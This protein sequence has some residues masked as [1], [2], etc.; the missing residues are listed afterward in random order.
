MDATPAQN[1]ADE[2][3]QIYDLWR[4]TGEMPTAVDAYPNVTM[5]IMQNSPE[6]SPTRDKITSYLH[7][8]VDGTLFQEG[9]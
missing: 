9:S 6:K 3:G 7:N 1:S 2:L 5:E 4:T 8:G